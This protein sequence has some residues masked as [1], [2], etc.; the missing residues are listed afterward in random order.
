MQTVSVR[1]L[2]VVLSVLTVVV[3]VSTGAAVPTAQAASGVAST[4]YVAHVVAQD[5]S[6]RE[7]ETS[8]PGESSSGEPELD[9]QTEAEAEK[10]KNKVV[11]GVIA[12]ILLGIVAAGRYL[13]AKKAK[14]G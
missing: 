8:E 9:P 5:E 11:V 12:A 3:V 4:G 10:N 1:V 2:G 7:S 6:T 14:G 13:R